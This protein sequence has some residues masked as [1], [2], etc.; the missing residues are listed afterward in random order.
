MTLS[1]QIAK[2]F[3]Q[4]LGNVNIQRYNDG[5]FNLHLKNLLEDPEY[6]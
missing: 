3:G 2:H 1:N 5:N 4:E 6:L